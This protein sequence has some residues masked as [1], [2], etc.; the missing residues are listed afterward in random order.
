MKKGESETGKCVGCTPSFKVLAP[1]PRPEAR[2]LA[3]EK[4]GS[5]H[6]HADMC[7]HMCIQQE[8]EMDVQSCARKEQG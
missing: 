6:A 1:V 7:A 3:G 5:E 4:W 8:R 2:M